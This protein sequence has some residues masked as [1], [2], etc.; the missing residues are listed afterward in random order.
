MTIFF[1]CKPALTTTIHQGPFSK[2]SNSLGVGT[3]KSSSKNSSPL[4]LFFT[5]KEHFFPT[6]SQPPPPYP[7]TSRHSLHVY[8]QL[9]PRAHTFALRH[10]QIWSKD[11]F[12]IETTRDEGTNP[13]VTGGL[14]SYVFFRL[15]FIPFYC[16]YY[17]RRCLLRPFMQ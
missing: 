11:D 6:D 1:L 10:S 4:A 8:I 12:I 17:Y 3:Q 7:I 9:L 16:Y 13:I 15:V 14:F 2:I 5:K